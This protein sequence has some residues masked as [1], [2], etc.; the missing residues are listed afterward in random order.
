MSGSLQSIRDLLA[1]GAHVN[2]E[3]K[4]RVKRGTALVA[5]AR[6]GHIEAVQ[7]L[8]E[9]GARTLPTEHQ[10]VQDCIAMSAAAYGGHEDIVSLLVKQMELSRGA[11][12]FHHAAYFAA[13]NGHVKLALSLMDRTID[14][15]FRRPVPGW[16]YWDMAA[17]KGQITILERFLEFGVPID[18][19]AEPNPENNGAALTCAAAKGR[20]S[21]VHFLLHRGADFNLP[22]L[23]YG[24]PLHA[25]VIG[26]HLDVVKLL[27]DYGTDPTF[28]ANSYDPRWP[29]YFGTPLEEATRHGH[30]DIAD[31]LR[32]RIRSTENV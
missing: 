31:L 30:V 6:Y 11:Y 9:M 22:S 14:P 26:G 8:I 32:A 16:A 18:Y 1:T 4:V 29:F 5:A 28:L 7:Y 12:L 13:S 24:S 25:A 2:A 20:T 23:K 15:D 10:R 21:T 17:E 27:L 3:Y 19:I